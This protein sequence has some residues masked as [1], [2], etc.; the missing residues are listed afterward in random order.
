MIKVLPIVREVYP[1]AKFGIM[2]A[3]GLTAASERSGMDTLKSAEIDR[4][5]TEHKG[6]ERKTVL[7]SKP[8]CYY[9]AYYKKFKKTYPV[10]LQLESILLKNKGIPNAGV[11]VESMFL[12][13]VN[14]LLLT[15]GHDLNHINGIL[16][17]NI[18]AGTVNVD[19]VTEEQICKH[20]ENIRGYLLTAVP[21]VEIQTIEVY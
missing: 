15:A 14:N 4:I 16:M 7:N 10:L 2:I 8:I 11:P 21:H 13:E 9:A 3:S 19:G 12:A 20:L 18:A 6:Y 5:K 1:G 17:L